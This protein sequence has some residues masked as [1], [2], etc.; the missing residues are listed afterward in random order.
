MSLIGNSSLATLAYLDG[1][2]SNSFNNYSYTFYIPSRDKNNIAYTA[3]TDDVVIIPIGYNPSNPSSSYY[4]YIPTAA[5]TS[6]YETRLYYGNTIVAKST[7]KLDAGEVQTTK[8][9]TKVRGKKKTL[10]V[11][12]YKSNKLKNVYIYIDS[13]NNLQVYIDGS[14]ISWYYKDVL[15]S[16]SNT[17]GSTRNDPN[18]RQ[19]NLNR[20]GL[21]AYNRS[22]RSLAIG[23]YG[24]NNPINIDSIT[25]WQDGDFAVS[26]KISRT[27]DLVNILH[28][29]DSNI[30][31][32]E[33]YFFGINPS[34]YGMQ[35]YDVDLTSGPGYNQKVLVTSGSHEFKDSATSD[36]TKIVQVPEEQSVVS[37]VVSTS[38]KSKFLYLNAGE[39]F[40]PLSGQ[41]SGNFNSTKIYGNAIQKTGEIQYV[42]ESDRML[43]NDSE[44]QI[45]SD[46][47][48]SKENAENIASIILNSSIVSGNTF[49]IEAFGNPLLT[50]GDVVK[51][52]YY[53]TN[54][55]SDNYYMV[56]KANTSYSNG[57]NSSFT[58]R[59]IT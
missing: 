31:K 5:T 25:A 59:R 8:K 45:S 33:P 17:S 30:N 54:T 43:P 39:S 2:D 49:D 36:I 37:P 53:K 24:N 44:I 42:A 41:S 13:A 7:F 27:V 14:K 50:I 55:V 4:L 16:S 12:T 6:A 48:Q 34:V 29:G 11:K 21:A 22:G 57:F 28:E 58:L 3:L 46:W 23:V 56:T 32:A 1:K 9:V 51:V 47:I 18:P 15:V 20:T 40:I 52:K 19:Y 35:I 26:P 38:F 10:T